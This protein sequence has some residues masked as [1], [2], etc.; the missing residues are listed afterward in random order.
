MELINLYFSEKNKAFN[1]RANLFVGYILYIGFGILDYY[2]LHDNYLS[3]WK[4]RYLILSPIIIL[5][6]F[7]SYFKW[8]EKYLTHAIVAFMYLA[9]ISI[10][11]IIDF[12]TPTENAFD[13][14]YVGLILLIFVAAFIFRLSKTILIWLS[15]FTFIVYNFQ[16]LLHHSFSLSH[17]N[18]SEFAHFISSNT[19]L[20]STSLL[21]VFG[22]IIIG[23]FMKIIDKEKEILTKALLKAKESDKTKTSFLNTMSHEIRTPLNGIIGFSDLLLGDFDITEKKELLQGVN[24]QAYHLLNILTSMLEYSQLQSKEDLGEKKKKSLKSLEMEIINIFNFH[25]DKLK[26]IN[27]Q[28]VLEIDKGQ[29][30]SYIF[31]YQDKFKSVIEAVIENSIKFS[32]FGQ[33]KVKLSVLNGK[34]ILLSI[35]DKGIGIDNGLEQSIF[36]DF[37]QLETAHNRT[38]SGIG[39]GLSISNKIISLMEGKIWYEKNEGKGT[40][41]F[42]SIP[43]IYRLY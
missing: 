21:A 13:Q 6:F 5:T 16:I 23:N 14:Y 41:F 32:K 9:Q 8:F 7:I 1:F 15:T 28:L 11:I 10:F 39:M 18:N 24:R 25:Q 12:A 37:S 22:S 27:I 19:F 26:K 2:M 17:L 42:I 34:N 3:A 29:T 33:V 36:K 30:D 20:I 40:T 43:N 38:Y 31:T 4:V 35:C